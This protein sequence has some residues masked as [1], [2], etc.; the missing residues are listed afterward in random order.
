MSRGHDDEFDDRDDF[1]PGEERPRGRREEPDDEDDSQ[2]RAMS[3]TNAP[4]VL[5]GICGLL[6]VI[7]F[8]VIGFVFV[9]LL[10]T[11]PEEMEEREKLSQQM[12]PGM[13]DMMA[14]AQ[15]VPA[16]DRYRQALGMYGLGAFVS[17]IGVVLPLL[18]GIRMR[19][20]RNYM[21]CI[22]GAVTA[23]IPCV[24]GSAC[25]ALGMGVGIWAL[26]V[27]LSNDVKSAFR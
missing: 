16:A 27:L 20:L 6:N 26:V 15:S 24:S 1:E 8:M 12:F 23:A 7:Y 11:T 13:K 22:V 18:A 19:S 10:T 14:Q 4:G 5:L 21:L 3:K 25:C 17:L 2:T 9:Q